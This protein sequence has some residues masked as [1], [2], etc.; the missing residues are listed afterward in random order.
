MCLMLLHKISVVVVVAAAAAVVLGDD[1]KNWAIPGLFSVYFRLFKQILPLDQGSRDDV[2]L[3]FVVLLLPSFML[4]GVLRINGF[5]V[6]LIKFFL[7]LL[8]PMPI[9]AVSI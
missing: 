7:E 5:R 2:T 8:K 3:D 9:I 4:L 6:R 1:V